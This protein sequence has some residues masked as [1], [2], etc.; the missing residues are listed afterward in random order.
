[1]EFRAKR[2]MDIYS[3]TDSKQA[4]EMIIA[5]DLQRK[6][7]VKEMTGVNWTNCLNYNVCIDTQ[8]TGFN[9]ATEIISRLAQNVREKAA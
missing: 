8:A 1:M 7:F 4:E 3:I 5:S 6:N 9:A 2:I